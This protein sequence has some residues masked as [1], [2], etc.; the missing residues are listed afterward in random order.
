MDTNLNHRIHAIRLWLAV[1]P[2]RTMFHRGLVLSGR[3]ADAIFKEIDRMRMEMVRQLSEME[4]L[5]SMSSST[6]A[7]VLPFPVRS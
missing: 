1:A 5:D 3:D 2:D 6:T 7:K 4:S